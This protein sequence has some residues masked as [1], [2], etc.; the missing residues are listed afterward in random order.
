MLLGDKTKFSIE[1][2]V[3]ERVDD[4]VFGHFLFWLR[5]KPVGDWEDS[6]D[7]KGCLRW[8]KKFAS[9]NHNRYE[10]DLKDLDK[11]SVF[12]LL[13]NSV[14]FSDE[15]EITPEPKFENIFSRFHISHIGMSSFDA[16]DIL[17]I[18]PPDSE[19][20]CLWRTQTDSEI[21]ECFLPQGEM[22]R[23]AALCST[24]RDSEIKK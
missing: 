14:M 11:I 2:E 24:A 7:L 21:Q 8:L 13:Y 10:P 15:N 20:R 1:Y 23:V 22:Q 18:E 17:L 19:Q 9:E 16:Y 4:W 12:K 5:G 3:T 6:T